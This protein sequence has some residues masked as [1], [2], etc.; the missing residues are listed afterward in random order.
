[1]KSYVELVT[2]RLE[3]RAANILNNIEKM[4]DHHLRFTMRIFGDCV[5]GEARERLFG[6]Y[7]EYLTEEELR[8]FTR[9][10]VP[11]YT[12]YAIAELGEK[13]KEG[14]RFD[15]PW[16]TQEEYQELSLREKWPRIGTFLEQV[17][18]L[19][20]VRELS[21][22]GLLFRPYM[23]SDPGFNEGVLEFALYYDLLDR[24][25]Q[26]PPETV[27]AA[28]RRIVPLLAEA[29]PL[30]GKAPEECGKVLARIRKE[31]AAAAG[32]EADPERLLGPEMERYP[33]TPP[34]GYNLRELRRTLAGMSLR[35]V[36]LS[37]LAHMELLTAEETGEIV[38]P[39]VSKYPSFFEIPGNPL[40][41][42]VVAI[43][44]R[45]EGRDLTY[46][47]DRYESGRMAMTKPVSWLVWRTMPEEEKLH[48]LREDNARMDLAMMSRHLARILRSSSFEEL[49]DRERMI[50][51]LTDGDYVMNHGSILKELGSEEGGETLKRL[52]DEATISFLRMSA[53]PRE[54]RPL[55]FARIRRRIS[56]KTKIEPDIVKKGE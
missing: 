14:E 50:S 4:G 54:E 29:M 51:L 17:P 53:L 32:I 20:L 46:F 44:E 37:A 56:E 22:L 31:V 5:D 24:L 13:K 16:L 45:T 19:Q 23:L 21:R 3:D 25:G 38:R 2:R 55:G 36:R 6:K 35:D 30:E 47:F 48:F 33:R 27:R 8:E 39:Y 34:P 26:L 10:F 40:R 15:P 7:N 12:D 11:A 9:E 18:P 41:E 1:M 49:V 43:A 42:M 52:Y 28:A